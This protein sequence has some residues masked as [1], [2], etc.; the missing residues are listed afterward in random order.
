MSAKFITL[1]GNKTFESLAVLPDYTNVA[2]TELI[3]VPDGYTIVSALYNVG[4]PKY[5]RSSA[6]PRG[7]GLA[8]KVTESGEVSVSGTFLL[9]RTS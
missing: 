5:N 4:G 6:I 1:S 2:A 8:I 3:T 9:M 7:T